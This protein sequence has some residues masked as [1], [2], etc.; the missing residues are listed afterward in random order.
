[1]TSENAESSGSPLA[2]ADYRAVEVVFTEP[3]GLQE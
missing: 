2:I 1:M 3:S